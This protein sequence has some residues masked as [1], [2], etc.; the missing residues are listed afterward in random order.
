LAGIALLVGNMG[1]G[2][3]AAN[4]ICQAL[5]PVAAYGL[6][7]TLASR[8][9]G[10]LA[11]LFTIA[12]LQTFL[13]G[14][15]IMSES[16]Y[17]CLLSFAVLTTAVA[18]KRERGVANTGGQAASG[19]RHCYDGWPWCWI[20]A[21]ILFALA[22]LTRSAAIAPIT[23]AVLVLI[24]R[25]RRARPKALVSIAS[26]SL[27]V[28]AAFVFE[29][30]LND[31]YAGGFKPSTGTFG[32][33]LMMKTR[34]VAALPFPHTPAAERCIELLP[35]RTPDEAYLANSLDT[36]VA[37]YQAVHNPTSSLLAKGGNTEGMSDWQ[38]DALMRRA[39]MQII[40]ENPVQFARSTAAL[41]ISYLLRKKPDPTDSPIPPVKRRKIIVHPRAPDNQNSQD[42]WYAWWALPA[43]PLHESLLLAARM[44]KS[45]DQKAPFGQR[46]IW[47]TCRYLSMIPTT[48]SPIADVSV[49][50]SLWPFWALILCRLLRLNRTI[51]AFLAIT[52]IFD[53]GMV[54]LLAPSLTALARYQDIW[55]AVDTTL[56]AALVGQL[57]LRLFAALLH[58]S[59]SC[60]A[61]GPTT[62]GWCENPFSHPHQADTSRRLKN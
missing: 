5:L 4:H 39:A 7:R 2:A 42:R 20:C 47:Q 33:M 62:P 37:R 36:W 43:L 17:A 27:P 53:A 19:T 15:R 44:Q 54:A 13:W 1:W 8:W 49:V 10:Y 14:E 38:F 57:L 59:P 22:W 50:A 58:S 23:A 48:V 35:Q 52:Y 16:F 12:R 31:Y 46:G 51:C 3:V 61:A 21:G 24:W 56:S 41:S 45:A 34:H 30:S 60:L 11:A 25:F 9:I 28:A 26:I 29:C 6:G 18:L 55:I 32:M 40:T